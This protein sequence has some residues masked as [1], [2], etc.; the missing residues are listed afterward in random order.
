[1]R[2]R[3]CVP[4]ETDNAAGL[5]EVDTH[6]AVAR[7]PRTLPSILETCVERYSEVSQHSSAR[8]AESSPG[9]MEFKSR[10]DRQAV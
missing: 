9:D 2:Y 3:V 4:A 5:M 7:L 10:K 8:T 6:N 1:M